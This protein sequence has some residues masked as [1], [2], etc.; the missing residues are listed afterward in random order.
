MLNAM[1]EVGD[2]STEYRF[3]VWIAV[4]RGRTNVRAAARATAPY[5]DKALSNTRWGQIERGFER[6]GGF[7]IPVN[8]KPET[9]A[10]M[11]KA[12]DADVAYGL[13]LAGFNPGDYPKLLEP[14]IGHGSVRQAIEGDPLLDDR[15]R[16]FVLD[17]YDREVAREAEV[18]RQAG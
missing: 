17:V 5:L 12:V 8:P 13:E 18:R 16:R 2:G 4:Q 10:A 9:I 1:S 11:C 3:G 15:G 7:E 14:A 6:K